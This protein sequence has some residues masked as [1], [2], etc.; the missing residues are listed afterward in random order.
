M[1]N[2]KLYAQWNY[3]SRVKV[4][5]PLGMKDLRNFSN[6]RL[7]LK[8]LFQQKEKWILKKKM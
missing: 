8:E 5:T 7:S 1:L 4:K 6:H 3:Y 2:I